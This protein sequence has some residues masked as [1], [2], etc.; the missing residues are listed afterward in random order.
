[1]LGEKEQTEKKV[2]KFSYRTSKLEIQADAQ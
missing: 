2:V 1:M